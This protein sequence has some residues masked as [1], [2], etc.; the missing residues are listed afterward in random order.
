MREKSPG[1]GHAQATSFVE[2]AGNGDREVDMSN[3]DDGNRRELR[4]KALT[5]SIRQR[6][7]QKLQEGRLS[8]GE[9]VSEDATVRVYQS[10]CLLFVCLFVCLFVYL[11]VCLSVSCYCSYVP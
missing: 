6:M 4:S 10:L 9:G 11:Y 7:R 5:E 2:T 1:S 8:I 3:D